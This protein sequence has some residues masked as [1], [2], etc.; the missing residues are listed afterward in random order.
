MDYK[1]ENNF[2]LQKKKENNFVKKCAIRRTSIY[3]LLLQKKKKKEL[4]FF[5]SKRMKNE[6]R[7][8]GENKLKRLHSQKKHKLSMLAIRNFI[9]QPIRNNHTDRT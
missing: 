4:Q 3:F 7:V 6:R 9:N 5:L 8:K 1:K 2:F